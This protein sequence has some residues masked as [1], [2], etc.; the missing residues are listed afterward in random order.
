MNY[1]R[2]FISNYA[3]IASFYNNLLKNSAIFVFNEKCRLAFDTLKQLLINQPV[4][5]LYNPQL[6]TKLHT[7]ASTVAL[8]AILLQKQDSVFGPQWLITVN[9]PIE[10]R[11][12]TIALS[13]K[14]WRLSNLLN[15]SIFTCMV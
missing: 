8:A 3:S 4:L 9:Q 7:D 1:F 11:Q 12:I 6:L 10:L 13:W 15:V 2:K 5:K 14:C